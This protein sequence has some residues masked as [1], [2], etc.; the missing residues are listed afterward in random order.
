MIFF[1]EKTGFYYCPG[2][3]KTGFYYYSSQFHALNI[4]VALIKNENIVRKLVEISKAELR[5]KYEE[6]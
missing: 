6:N 5:F 4:E 3:Y 2:F 1:L